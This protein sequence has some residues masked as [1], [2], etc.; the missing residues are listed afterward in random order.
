MTQVI[1]D[2]KDSL[3]DDVEDKRLEVDKIFDK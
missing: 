2:F 3:P 1:N